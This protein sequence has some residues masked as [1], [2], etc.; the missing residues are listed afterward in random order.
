MS[1]RKE[2]AVAVLQAL[3]VQFGDSAGQLAAKV[4]RR[5]AQGPAVRKYKPQSQC[6]RKVRY[7]SKDDAMKG[8][9]KTGNVYVQPYP[10][11]YCHGWHNGNAPR[12]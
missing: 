3:G 5:R 1:E 9:R 12:G 7:W 11:V 10:C 2:E 4:E 6:V 8:A